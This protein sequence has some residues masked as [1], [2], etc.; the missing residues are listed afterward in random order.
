MQRGGVNNSEAP[1]QNG[2]VPTLDR[3]VVTAWQAGRPPPKFWPKIQSLNASP[4]V[5]KIY[6]R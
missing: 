2:P 5:R 4:S 3:V 6:D 1:E